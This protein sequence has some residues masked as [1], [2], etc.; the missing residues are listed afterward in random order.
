MNGIGEKSA[1][2]SITWQPLRSVSYSRDVSM[3]F[4]VSRSGNDNFP[5]VTIIMPGSECRS[6]NENFDF[7]SFVWC[8]ADFD[9]V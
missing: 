6:T 3:V 9:L 1:P 7:F 4:M 2:F 8:L 5:T